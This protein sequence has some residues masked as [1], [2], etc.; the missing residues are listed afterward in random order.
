MLSRGR[1]RR[2]D[3]VRMGFGRLLRTGCVCVALGAVTTVVVAWACALLVNTQPVDQHPRFA[4]D[5][6]LPNK[7]TWASVHHK[8][9]FGAESLANLHWYSSVDQSAANDGIVHVE[10]VGGGYVTTIKP[11]PPSQPRR[12]RVPYRILRTHWCE[13]GVPRCGSAGRFVDAV[14]ARGW[15]FLA[16]CCTLEEMRLDRPAISRSRHLVA[17]PL[18]DQS[19]RSPPFPD[20]FLPLKPIPLGFA[21]DSGI[22][23]VVWAA[24]L[25][26]FARIRLARR[27]RRGLCVRC[28]YD[29]NHAPHDRCPECGL[30]TPTVG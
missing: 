9:G 30:P 5:L 13:L 8:R 12:F 26:A 6:N 18:N 25:I 20:H 14:D 16:L 28:R 7:P 19:F 27:R 10:I 3:I 24:L 23:A 4:V 15:P 1:P 21:I 29:L 17:L 22:Y 2:A 11:L